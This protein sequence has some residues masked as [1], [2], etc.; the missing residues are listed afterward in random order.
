MASRLA[1]QTT[2]HRATMPRGTDLSVRRSSAGFGSVADPARDLNRASGLLALSVLLDSGVEHYRGEFKNPMMVVPLLVSALTIGISA[3]G[4]RDC[5]EA[6]HRGRQAVYLAAA[7]TGLIG[8]GFHLYNVLKR[9]GRLDWQNAFYGAP[10]GAPIALTLSGALGAAA[11]RARSAN[12]AS[13]RIGRM[14]AAICAIGMFGSA[15]EAA[16]LHFRGSFNH[17]AMYVPVTVSPVAGALLASAALAPAAR[18]DLIVTRFWLK[19]TAVMGLIGTM[20]HIRGVQR[21]MGGWRNWSQN[22]LNG[23]PLPAPPSYTG[24]A[25]AGLAALGLIE[26][27]R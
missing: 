18:E 10:A 2:A 17:R 27:R 1:T 15:A 26:K 19:F 13:P 11:E 8:T 7:A 25:L 3:H 6:M 14:I 23:P 24:L 5:R 21:C 9:P 12:R 16:L 4:M 22:V 20:F